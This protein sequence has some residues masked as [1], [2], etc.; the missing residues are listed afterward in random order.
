[1]FSDLKVFLSDTVSPA[2]VD[3]YLFAYETIHRHF[4]DDILFNLQ[5]QL[6]TFKNADRSTAIVQ[7][8][9]NTL[10]YLID[11][12]KMYG[13]IVNEDN[14]EY[15]SIPKITNILYGLL[16]IEYFEDKDRLLDIGEMGLS[17]EETLAEMISVVSDNTAD[18]TLD[19][20]DR[21]NDGVLER[22]YQVLEENIDREVSSP[23]PIIISPILRFFIQSGLHNQVSTHVLNG[24]KRRPNTL[25]L[26]S[27]LRV[28]GNHTAD[29]TNNTQATY[30]WVF[31]ILASAGEHSVDELFNNWGR[32]FLEESSI[33]DLKPRVLR[34]YNEIMEKAN[35]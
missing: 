29:I 31:L 8:A 10:V 26:P 21:V 23:D 35:A 28:Y 32:Y 34:L 22:I 1:M 27:L 5:Q 7:L 11:A 19:L 15:T 3:D 12:L 6:Y 20:L 9:D 13:V 2:C 16:E 30:T 14:V 17:L 18:D 25:P 4:G 24:C 33:I